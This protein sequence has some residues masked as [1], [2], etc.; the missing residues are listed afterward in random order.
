MAVVSSIVELYLAPGGSF[1][2]HYLYEIKYNIIIMIIG[3]LLIIKVIII[4]SKL[5]IGY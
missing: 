5:F 4:I 3:V 1:L 2:R